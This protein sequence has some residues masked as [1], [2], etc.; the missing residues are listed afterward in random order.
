MRGLRAASC[1]ASRSPV[2]FLG[3]AVPALQP[4]K[5]ASRRASPP[6]QAR[7][8]AVPVH[9]PLTLS[10]PTPTLLFALVVPLFLLLAARLLKGITEYNFRLLG[11]DAPLSSCFVRRDKGRVGRLGIIQVCLMSI[12]LG[13]GGAR[14]QRDP[15]VS[16][17]TSHRFV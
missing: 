11:R 9:L 14:P 10:D 6:T 5:L 4:N 13:G 2:P 1:A 16:S 12:S 8:G 15:S 17:G 7:A 3:S